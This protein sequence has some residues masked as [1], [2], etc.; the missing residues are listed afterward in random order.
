M[1]GVIYRHTY[2]PLIGYEGQLP[3]VDSDVEAY[4]F[5]DALKTDM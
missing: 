1:F 4:L 5:P 2:P 3:F